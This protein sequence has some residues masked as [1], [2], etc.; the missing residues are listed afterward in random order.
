MPNL[1]GMTQLYPEI[2]PDMVMAM[3]RSNES[4][5][6]KVS[7]CTCSAHDEKFVA[8]TAVEDGAES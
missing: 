1:A 6:I 8:K 7:L 2:G 4:C 3:R 5:S